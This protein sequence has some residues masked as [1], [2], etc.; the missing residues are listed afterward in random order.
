VILEYTL[1]G[2]ILNNEHK[3]EH[4]FKHVSF[5]H[6]QIQRVHVQPAT[7]LDNSGPILIHL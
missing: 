6:V 1:K 4:S 2:Q 3:N 5:S 7:H